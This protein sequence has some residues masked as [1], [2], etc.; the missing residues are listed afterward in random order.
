M[1]DPDFT[2]A[3]VPAAAPPPAPARRFAS[4]DA[5][6]GLMVL[7]MVNQHFLAWFWQRPRGRIE[8]LVTAYPAQLGLHT[9]GAL[10]AP[11]FIALSGASAAILH[12]RAPDKSRAL[13]QIALTGVYLLALGYLLNLV[14]YGWFRPGSW[15]VLHLMGLGLMAFPLLARVPVRGLVVVA[16]VTMA[17]AV[18][19]QSTLHT[20]MRLSHP[21]MNRTELPGGVLRLMFVEGHFPVLPWLA[22]FVL[23]PVAARAWVGGA[24]GVGAGRAVLWRVAGLLLAVAVVLFCAQWLPA[25]PGLETLGEYRWWRYATRLSL[26]HYPTSPLTLCFLLSVGFALLA[27]FD[28][29]E[30]RGQI[31]DGD[32]LVSVGRASLTI[33]IVHVAVVQG[34]FKPHGYTK[35]LGP[36]AVLVLVAAMI[37][38]ATICAHLWRRIDYAYGFEW[39]RRKLIR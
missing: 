3:P 24:A 21:R 5:L 20:P 31:T 19:A 22:C 25:V 29:R 15:Y 38:L 37:A 23:G 28:R 8:H 33:F 16:F 12:A 32:R 17:L 9:L 35:S 27:L 13:R 6:R 18:W 7:L 4:L 39:L 34:Y 36:V 14:A 11:M 1:S 2:A 30:A 26:R 10:A